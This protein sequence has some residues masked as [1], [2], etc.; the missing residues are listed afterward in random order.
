MFSTQTSVVVQSA[1][2]QKEWLAGTIVAIEEDGRFTVQIGTKKEKNVDANRVEMTVPPPGLPKFMLV[3]LT[4]RF[5]DK[6]CMT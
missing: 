2:D 4:T 5:V 6:V 3:R 1:T